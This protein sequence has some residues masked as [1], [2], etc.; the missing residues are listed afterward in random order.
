MTG[1]QPRRRIDPPLLATSVKILSSGRLDHP[2]VRWIR[3]WDWSTIGLILI[4]KALVFTFAVQSVRMPGE[5]YDGWKEIWDRWDASHYL[6]LAKDG[7][8]ATGEGRYS[9]VFYPLY[10]AL[11][12][13][14]HFLTRNYLSAAFLVSGIA[15]VAAG[16]LLRRLARADESEEVS[17]NAVWFLFIFPTSFFLH[18]AY[19]ESLFLALT[20]GCFLAARANRWAVV[21]LLGALA[22]ATRVN[23]L[24]L[25][26][27]L[28]FEVFTQYRATRRIDW[29][30]LWLGV[31]PA[32][33]LFYL[34]LNH[35]V[36]GD[37]FAFSKIMAEHWY[38]KFA[39]PWIGIRDVWRR[40]PGGSFVEG[41][42]EFFYIVLVLACTIWCWVKS[43][44][45]YAVWMTV[46][47]LLINS[48][49][50]VLSV[51]RYALTLFPIFILFARLGTKRRLWYAAL[52]VWSLLYLGAYVG[53]FAQG[54]WAF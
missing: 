40:M 7:Y 4:I 38:K 2:W 49:S 30:W 11:V 52:T 45:S 3:G 1:D 16:L 15:S 53:R 21:G 25:L 8:V 41:Y 44:P 14:A 31:I 12:H 28:A 43:R 47:W 32:G 48:T 35:H 5:R 29:R 13:L 39:A 20:L 9:L 23:G 10:P 54:L 26:P 19:T 6:S 18:V 22:C 50:F 46:N 42:H 24:L 27:A 17:D 37:Y 51:P 36:T 33:F 34:W